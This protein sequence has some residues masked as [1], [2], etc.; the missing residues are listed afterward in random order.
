MIP[1]KYFITLVALSSLIACGGS[2]KIEITNETVVSKA[3]APKKD[4]IVAIS[5]TR[6]IA[7][8]NPEVVTESQEKVVSYAFNFSKKKLLSQILDEAKGTKKL[9]YL[10]ISASWCVPCQIMKRDV[11]ANIDLALWFNQNC[12]SHLVDV[13]KEE[14]PDL[15]TIFGVN[16]FPTMLI[17]DEKGRVIA[18]NEGALTVTTLTHFAKKN[19]KS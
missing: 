6:T 12:I 13:E 7:K 2:K 18:R 9:I 10:D 19:M 11:Y 17:L 1:L 5:P 8:A 14:G 16:K 15:G 3:K 4:T